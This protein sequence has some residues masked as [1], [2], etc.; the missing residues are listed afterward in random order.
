[1]SQNIN[2]EPTARSAGPLG[3][4]ALG[5]ILIGALIGVAL[6]L[7]TPQQAPMFALGGVGVGLGLIGGMTVSHGRKA[8]RQK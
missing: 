2:P 1:M 6:L 4:G 3:L 5:W 8:P 7:L